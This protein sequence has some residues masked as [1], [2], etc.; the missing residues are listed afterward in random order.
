MELVLSKKSK[1]SLG[2]PLI[3]SQGRPFII[4]KCVGYII[5]GLSMLQIVEHEG[6][7]AHTL[8]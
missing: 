8:W 2:L 6:N 3:V 5:L 7:H 4:I 1:G